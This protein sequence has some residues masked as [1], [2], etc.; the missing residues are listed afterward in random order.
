M[1]KRILSKKPKRK[2]LSRKLKRK[3]LNRK[4]GG[5]RIVTR[6]KVT[7]TRHTGNY[8]SEE[9]DENFRYIC[10]VLLMI[11][12][13]SVAYLAHLAHRPSGGATFELLESGKQ[14]QLPEN[15]KSCIVDKDKFNKFL[16]KVD[17][18]DNILTID[19]KDNL[20]DEEITKL[21]EDNLLK[22]YI[23]ADTTSVSFD[24]NKIPQTLYGINPFIDKIRILDSKN[25]LV[26]VD[27][28]DKAVAEIFKEQ[29]N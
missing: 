13:V 23:K 4:K 14:F 6:G 7:I 9:A 21:K 22:Q 25:S 10:I 16:E 1:A 18:T 17:I 11:V 19:T 8:P 27:C 15:F 20:T 28:I 29:K 26:N 24:L 2:Q 5:G 3:T 12:G